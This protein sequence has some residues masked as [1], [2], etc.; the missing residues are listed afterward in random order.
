MTRLLHVTAIKNKLLSSFSSEAIGN[1]RPHL[2]WAELKRG[3]VITQAGAPVK[4][5]YCVEDG[6]ISVIKTMRNGQVVEVGAI[7]R[8]GM[9]APAAMFGVRCHLFDTVVQ[10]PGSA[11][12]FRA[13][14]L[15][16]A[17]DR[18][19]ELNLRLQDYLRFTVGQLVRTSA[20]NGLHALT[21]RCCRWLLIAHDSSRSD[22]IHLTHE[23]L[24]IM[25]GVL[26]PSVSLVLGELKRDGLIEI[27][28]GRILIKKRKALEERSCECY[29]ET[30][31]EL[32]VL[33]GKSDA[34]F[35]SPFG[36]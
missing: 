8:E 29:L 3:D 25:L 35:L 5:H 7:G 34:A 17:A 20:C 14:I 9:T 15:Q 12:R 1:I 4:W 22:E 24:A 30:Q 23:F 6:L 16:Q 11:L 26:R 31:E 27:A 28:H 18:D 13:E 33:Y 21:Q 2:E 10:V 19:R 36:E 32:D